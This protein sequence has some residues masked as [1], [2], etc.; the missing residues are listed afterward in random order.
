MLNFPKRLVI[1]GTEWN[2]NPLK[3]DV[4]CIQCNG[5]TPSWQDIILSGNTALTLVNAKANGLNYVKLFGACEQNG[6]PSPDTPVDIVSNNGAL[7]ASCQLLTNGNC[8]NNTD[9]WVLGFASYNNTDDYITFINNTS[10]HT[11]VRCNTNNSRVANHTYA[12]LITGKTETGAINWGSRNASAAGAVVRTTEQTLGF[13]DTFPENGSGEP[14]ITLLAGDTFVLNKKSGFRM[15]DLT[16]LG[17][18]AVITTPRQAIDY[19]GTIYRN[20]KEIYTDGTIETVTDSLSNTATAEML[21]KVG[22]YQDV[23]EVLSGNV[24]RNVMVKV[25]DG[26]ETVVK[27][28]S[29]TAPL[30]YYFGVINTNVPHIVDSNGYCSHFANTRNSSGALSDSTFAFGSSRRIWFATSKFTEASDFQQYLADQYANGT[31]VIV[32]YPL[33]EPTTETVTGQALTT[34]AGT[35]IVEITQASIDNLALEVSYKGKQ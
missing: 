3:F 23:Q 5:S 9:N 30:G 10:D 22:D 28:S 27:N 7:K 21:S 11:Y 12:Y 14:W 35:N 13:I 15:F 31:P 26:S 19:F 17:L 32:V 24:T 29:S 20:P 1:N 2:N 25:L 18:D 34:Q 33:A 4:N 16:A 6:T 8:A